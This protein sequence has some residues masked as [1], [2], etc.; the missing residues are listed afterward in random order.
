LSRAVRAAS[1]GAVYAEACRL[2]Q[3][4]QQRSE[5]AA[6]AGAHVDD[7][8]RP[9]G[10]AAR[11]ERLQHGLDERFGVRPRLKRRGGQPE[12]KAPELPLAENAG[13]RLAGEPPGREARKA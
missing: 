6:C 13:H 9:V 1:G 7:G 11:P 4:V 2:G 5:N 12:G 3:L 8:E 10:V